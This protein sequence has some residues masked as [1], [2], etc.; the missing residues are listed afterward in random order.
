MRRRGYFL[1]TIVAVLALAIGCGGD[2][3]T[4][5]EETP[6][7]TTVVVDA[8][9]DAL[10]ATWQLTGPGS[11]I[12]DGLGDERLT[13]LTSGNYTITWDDFPG[14]NSPNPISVT[15][16]AAGGDSATFSGT[17]WQQLGTVMVDAEPNIIYAGWQLTGPNAYSHNGQ[18]DETLPGMIPGDY[19]IT[20]GSILGWDSPVPV[21]ETLTVTDAATT[22]FAGTYVL[23]SGLVALDITNVAGSDSGYVR[24]LD[25]PGLEPTQLTLEA[26]ITP[27]G[28]GIGNPSDAFGAALVAKPIEGGAGSAVAGYYLAWSP[29]NQSIAFLISHSVP[30]GGTWLM[31]PNMSAPLNTTSHVAATFN[32]TTMSIYINGTLEATVATASANI[33]YRASDVLIG[34]AN[35]SSPYLRR[36]DGNIDEV[37]IWDHARSAG[38]IAAT[39]NCQLAGTEMGL[40]AYWSFESGTLVDDSGNG[41]DGTAIVETGVPM[42][43]VG[44]QVFLGDCP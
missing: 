27:Q 33:D 6:K 19:S 10:D 42:D 8:T 17:Y 36:F 3:G 34:A 1:T 2:D 22:T 13:G 16:N 11:Y 18:G 14:W 39:M 29:T 23:A 9:P 37:R 32:G 24:V 12:H 31:T 5:P 38:N 20:W 26:W 43:F 25:D 4:A 7:K 44:P 40:L 21:N 15:M 35:F 41:H 30:N 28:A